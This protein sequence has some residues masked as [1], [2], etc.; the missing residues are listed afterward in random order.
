MQAESNQLTGKRK[1]REKTSGKGKTGGSEKVQKVE[2]I[3]IDTTSDEINKI[4]TQSLLQQ[5][6]TTLLKLKSNDTMWSLL[7]QIDQKSIEYKIES[8]VKKICE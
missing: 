6:L 3:I 2:H 7:K 1:S 5:Q 8:L 4:Q